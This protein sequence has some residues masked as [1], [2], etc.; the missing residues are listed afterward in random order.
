MEKKIR[1]DPTTLIYQ[2]KSAY[3]HIWTE[4]NNNFENNSKCRNKGFSYLPL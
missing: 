4:Y 3:L 2:E 1:V